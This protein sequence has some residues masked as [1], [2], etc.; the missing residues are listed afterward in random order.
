VNFGNLG[1]VILVIWC[2]FGVFPDLKMH[3]RD[4]KIRGFGFWCLD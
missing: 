3:D 1:G 2:R 4:L